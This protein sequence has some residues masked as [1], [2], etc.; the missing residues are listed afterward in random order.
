MMSLHSNKTK[1]KTDVHT[2]KLGINMIGL[3]MLLFG[4]MWILGLW[5]MMECFKWGLVYHTSR[6][7]KDSG[8]EGDLNWGCCL[9]RF[10]RRRVLVCDLQ[11]LF[12]IFW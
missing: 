12:V 1:T 4:G 11:T 9:K 10:Q 6:N 3:I 8:A 5:K 2:R 7:M